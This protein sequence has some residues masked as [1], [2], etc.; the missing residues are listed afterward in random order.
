MA[1]TS[2]LA[3]EHVATCCCCCCGSGGVQT[4][5]PAQPPTALSLEALDCVLRGRFTALRVRSNAASASAVCS[6]M[7][8]ASSLV[9][10]PAAQAPV[11]TTLSA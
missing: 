9:S 11:A 2:V 10:Q 5:Q 6:L 4:P 1:R 3:G 7:Y 8:A